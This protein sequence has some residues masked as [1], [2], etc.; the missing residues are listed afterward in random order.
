MIKVNWKSIL[1]G[2]IM[3]R[4]LVLCL[5]ILTSILMLV[6]CNGN[7]LDYKTQK[8]AFKSTSYY[9][10]KSVIKERNNYKVSINSVSQANAEYKTNKD[11]NV[12]LYKYAPYFNILDEM[13]IDYNTSNSG[14]EKYIEKKYDKKQRKASD[15][16][17]FYISDYKDGV[18]ISIYRGDAVNLKIPDKLDG[19]KVIKIGTHIVNDEE[20]FCGCASPF[21]S[22]K[23]K[24]ITIPS[25]V[26]YIS[27]EALN[28]R[29]N[30][31]NG[32]KHFLGKI[33]VDKNNPYYTSVDG[34]LYN[35]D[36]TCL[37]QIPMNYGKSTVKIPEGIKAV[38][39]INADTTKK[40]IIPSTVES[41]GENI[42]KNGDYAQ[43]SE[44]PYPYS[45]PI[46]SEY[47]NHKIK[48]FKVSEN[49][50]FYSSED[51]V[52]YNKPKTIL[53]A[54]PKAKDNKEFS[55]PESVKVIGETVDFSENGK[56]QTVVFGKNIV[57]IYGTVGEQQTIKG[58]KGTVAEKEA[59]KTGNKFV[60]L[61]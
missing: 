26:K 16:P 24:S 28:D 39:C 54:Y 29:W 22:S 56:L 53:L 40:I 42:D 25:T 52:L 8:Q 13:Y 10:N 38:Y 61:G 6:S 7:S 1:G 34:I 15:N 11:G 60:A 41:F 50:K 33:Y 47:F 58:Y 5:L 19:K 46:T 35:K 23:L 12:K 14:L 21:N 45:T 18:E 49:N 43:N 27:Y 31:G 51:G 17:N 3:K 59:K 57:Q 48:E 36:K 9:R 20:L 32:Y 44:T 30:E 55:V 4:L 2:I 37:L